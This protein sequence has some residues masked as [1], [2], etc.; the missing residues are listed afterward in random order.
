VAPIGEFRQPK[1][2][3]HYRAT[4]R[5]F[6]PRVL[7]WT[8]R[9]RND[10]LTG[11]RA[12]AITVTLIGRHDARNKPCATQVLGASCVVAERPRVNRTINSNLTM[13]F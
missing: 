13:Y 10:A 8:S 1:T 9:L 12:I 5:K 6:L 4:G 2:K 7:H 11:G 3:I